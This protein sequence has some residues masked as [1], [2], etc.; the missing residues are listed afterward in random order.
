M[1]APISAT[2][3]DKNH[4]IDASATIRNYGSSMFGDTVVASTLSRDM[5]SSHQ[6]QVHVGYDSQQGLDGH[7]PIG[8]ADTHELD[9]E[10]YAYAAEIMGVA[11]SESDPSMAN[12]DQKYKDKS[13]HNH[14][15]RENHDDDDNQH[16]HPG[17]PTTIA[18][19]PTTTADIIDAEAQQQILLREKRHLLMNISTAQ[20]LTTPT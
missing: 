13:P 8:V 10:R 11:A 17:T 1:V 2:T 16:I 7:G 15:R 19:A 18:A 5:P 4:H 14:H 20:A 6:F 9:Y 3:F 12:H